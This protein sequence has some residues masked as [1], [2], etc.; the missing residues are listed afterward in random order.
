MERGNLINET[1]K[2]QIALAKRPR[3]DGGE[4]ESA[5][6]CHCERNEI[7][8]GNLIN[9]TRKGQIAL[10]E[11]PRNDGGENEQQKKTVIASGEQWSAVERS[12]A[13]WSAAIS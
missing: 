4:Y 13:Q 9:E 10:A 12:G 1:R 3:N 7:E 2:V 6:N 5:I 8:R 11:R